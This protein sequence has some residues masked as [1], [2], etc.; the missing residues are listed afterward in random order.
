MGLAAQRAVAE[1]LHAD[2]HKIVRSLALSVAYFAPKVEFNQG[3][4]AKPR[5]SV[6]IGIVKIVSSVATRRIFDGSVVNANADR[7]RA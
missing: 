3:F 5:D 1:S 7:P 2:P 6:A 4:P